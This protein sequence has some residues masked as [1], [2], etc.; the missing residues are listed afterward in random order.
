MSLNIGQRIDVAE[1]GNGQP[2]PGCSIAV[3]QPGT[4]T[5]ASLFSNILGTVPKANPFLADPNG[6]YQY[7]AATG[8]YDENF[9]GQGIVT[10]FT[11]SNVGCPLVTVPNTSGSSNTV[12][13][14]QTYGIGVGQAHGVRQGASIASG[15]PTLTLATPGAF[16]FALS[17]VGKLIK[18]MGAGSAAGDLY[19]TI[20][21]FISSTQVTLSVNAA[22][23]VTNANAV[24]FTAGQDAIDRA[25]INAAIAAATAIQAKIYG[26]GA[27]YLYDTTPTWPTGQ[28]GTFQTLIGDGIRSTFFCASNVNAG[29][30]YVN[31]N[32][33]RWESFGGMGQGFSVW[34]PQFAV[35]AILSNIQMTGNVITATVSNG[36]TLPTGRNIYLRLLSSTNG[37]IINNLKLLVTASSSTQFT[38]TGFTHADIPSTPD[39]GVGYVVESAFQVDGGI[40]FARIQEIEIWGFQGAGI[41]VSTPILNSWTDIWV[42]HCGWAG[43]SLSV[44]PP[45]AVG[46]TVHGMLNCYALNCYGPGLFGYYLQSS[47]FIHCGF[48]QCGGGVILDFCEACTFTSPHIEQ[49]F[50]NDANVLPGHFIELRSCRNIVFIAPFMIT[51]SGGAATQSFICFNSKSAIAAT[52]QQNK[53]IRPYAVQSTGVF[54]T[55]NVQFQDTGSEWNTVDEI[56]YNSGTLT[57]SDLGSNNSLT[58]KGNE[59]T[60][61]PQSVNYTGTSAATGIDI[62]ANAGAGQVNFMRPGETTNRLQILDSGIFLGAGGVAALDMSIVRTSNGIH[63]HLNNSG[64]SQQW[65]CNLTGDAFSRAGVEVDATGNVAYFLGSDGTGAADC[66]L[67]RQGVNSWGMGSGHTSING[68]LTLA[69]L[70]SGVLITG[71]AVTT[72]GLITASSLKVSGS[73]G[74]YGTTPI[75]KPTVTGS[76]G[77][78]AALAS[79]LTQLAALGLITDSTT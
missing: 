34:G 79:L 30:F 14:I 17:D 28:S 63:T 53:L 15:S 74:F 42:N 21:A 44:I 37:K 71:V 55:F 18:V 5:L 3:Y 27:F 22:T 51:D 69:N 29:S 9:T 24:W 70:T 46:A 76:K 41:E 1:N 19:A 26:P 52:C 48:E 47:S 50:Q 35:P 39:T 66:F 25:A 61:G 78:N 54:Q 4:T 10:A 16:L 73:V 72:S 40:W 7:F 62:T 75:S 45:K 57:F 59:K 65:D 11:L 31:A 20:S 64:I 56:F 32:A 68:T 77:A 67:N 33:P 6:N 8:V 49:I 36:V 43:Y 23:T 13:N 60:Q 38:A 2:L 12:L 58:Y